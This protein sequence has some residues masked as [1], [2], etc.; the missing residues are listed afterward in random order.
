MSEDRVRL[1]G[2]WYD[3]SEQKEWVVDGARWKFLLTVGRRR[4]ARQVLVNL[5]DDVLPVHVRASPS[6]LVRASQLKRYPELESAIDQWGRHFRLCDGQ[7][8]TWT[9][10]YALNTL[11]LWQRMGEENAQPRVLEFVRPVK[12][13]WEKSELPE[14]AFRAWLIQ[15]EPRSEYKRELCGALNKY[16]DD[17]EKAARETGLVPDTRSFTTEHFEWLVRRQVEGERIGSIATSPGRETSEDAVKK[18]L[19][20]LRKL[21]DLP[22]PRP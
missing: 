6:R 18:A 12:V 7:R 11:Y 10:E 19:T 22:A 3:P 21:L 17:E 9:I 20:R 15:L 14:F 8:G 16:L 1:G 2:A 4:K 13:Y 5:R